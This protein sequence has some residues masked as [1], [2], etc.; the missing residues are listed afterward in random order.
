[1]PSSMPRATRPRG[2]M[3]GVSEQQTKP[4][5]PP[6][7]TVACAIVMVGSVFVVLLVWDRIAGLH[8]LETQTGPADLPGPLRT[9]DRPAS[10][11]GSLSAIVKVVSMVS[12]ACAVAMVVLGWQVAQ[13]SHSA[14]VAVSVLAVPLFLTGL[15]GDGLRR[16]RPPRRSGAPVSALRC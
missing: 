15:V 10:T 7:V 13:R 12:A 5:R 1:M 2:A 3:E 16:R 9:P 4:V 11:S 14:R 6:Q 8:T